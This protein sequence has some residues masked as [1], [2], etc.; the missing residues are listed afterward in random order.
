MSKYNVQINFRVDCQY[1]EEIEAD[2]PEEAERLFKEQ[3]QFIEVYGSNV[4]G[5]VEGIEVNGSIDFDRPKVPFGG[6]NYSF[7][8]SEVSS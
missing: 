6:N 5:S 8:T 2:S 4:D 1:E 3:H 7:D